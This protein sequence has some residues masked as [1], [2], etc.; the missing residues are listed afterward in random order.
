M[1]LRHV[2]EVFPQREIESTKLLARRD[3]LVESSGSYSVS[4]KEEI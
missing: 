1:K 4:H 2:P 3:R